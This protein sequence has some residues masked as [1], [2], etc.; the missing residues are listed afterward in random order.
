MSDDKSFVDLGKRP[1]VETLSFEQAQEELEQIVEELEDRHT[2]LDDALGLWERGEALHAWC[3]SRLDHAA[4][5]LHKLTVTQEEI[6]AVTAEGASDFA[7]DSG[8]S[9][10]GAHGGYFQRPSFYR[11]LAD[12]LSEG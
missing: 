1:A 4:E 9:T 12:R 10:L 5:R 11:R 8:Y 6:A 2:G 7:Y 3:Q